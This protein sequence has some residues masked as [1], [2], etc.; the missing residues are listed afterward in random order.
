MSVLFIHNT[1]P[2][3]RIP[4]FIGL[5]KKINVDYLFTDIN[6]SKKI[7]GYKSAQ[8]DKLAF[9]VLSGGFGRVFKLK[10]LIGQKKYR[11]I[12]LPPMDS[13]KGFFDCFIILIFG[14]INKSKLLYFGEKWE[15]P[16]KTQP[17][18]KKIKNLIQ[19]LAF[20]FILK[21]VDMCI[22]SGYKSEQFFKSIGIDDKNI[23]I[24]IDSSGVNEINN[25]IDIKKERQISSDCKIIL[26]YGRIIRRK[27]L[28]I[29]IKAYE[30]LK[31]KYQNICLF[32]CGEG[33]YKKECEILVDELNLKDV[34][35][36]GYIDPCNKYVYFSQ[37]N[38]FVLPSYFYM[39][40]PEAWGLTVNEALQCGKPVIA[41]K[42][43]GSAY[44]L[45]DGNNGVMIES[46]NINEL[47]NA[48]EEFL[49]NRYEKEVSEA[50][51]KQYKKYNYDN[52]INGFIN[53]IDKCC[54]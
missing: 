24:A 52:M 5:K 29:L 50:C 7:Y 41:T 42:A 45:L 14:K 51:I 25:C 49:F 54:E 44:D 48:I 27:G 30:R 40:I 3:Y 20:K 33:D 31:I 39:G 8:K 15:A 16:K 35:F 17:I 11:Q 4:F 46:N 22:V 34:F 12:I 18:K 28:D 10:N 36:E 13:L 32:I 9:E 23:S 6:L 38:I 53:A 43:V 2:E 1:M 19:R 37:C 21:E 47:A 26:Y